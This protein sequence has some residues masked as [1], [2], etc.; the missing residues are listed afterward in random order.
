MHCVTNEQFR[1]NSW[2]A[3]HYK[4]PAHCTLNVKHFFASKSICVIQQTPYWPHLAPA[5]FSFF[6]K[7]KLALKGMRFSNINDIQHG[8]TEQLKG[9][10]LQDFQHTLKDLYK[11][12]QCYMK[13]GGGGGGLYCKFVIK[14]FKYIHFF[15]NK[16]SLFI[17]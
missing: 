4:A 13:W 17:L 3:L 8:V 16:C 2:L 9:V 11:Q 12:S 7:M 15:H 5:D 14:T 6:F 10:S 1:N